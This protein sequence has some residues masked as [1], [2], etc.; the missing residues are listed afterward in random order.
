M[1]QP[2]DVTVPLMSKQKPRVIMSRLIKREDMDRSFDI[3]FWK[4]VGVQGKF[5]AAWDMV[6]EL[7]NW[8]S[9][10]VSQQGL[11]RTHTL[12]KRRGS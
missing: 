5:E 11:R 2:D 8:S 9:R 10:Y 4:R 1:T 3:Q 7:E 12:L 6:C